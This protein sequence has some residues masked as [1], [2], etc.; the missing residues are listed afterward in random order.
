MTVVADNTSPEDHDLGVKGCIYHKL[1]SVVKGCPT[2]NVALGD[3][4]AETGSNRARYEFCHGPHGFGA[5]NVNCQLFLDFGLS[6]HEID[7]T[8]VELLLQHR[9]VEKEVDLILVV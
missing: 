7:F 9:P 8:L 1:N 2:W 6:V 3:L 5:R 4:N